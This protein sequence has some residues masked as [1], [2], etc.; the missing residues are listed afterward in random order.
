MMFKISERFILVSVVCKIYVVSNHIH[1]LV[2]VL[3]SGTCSHGFEN[4]IHGLETG[5]HGFENS[6]ETGT[7]GFENSL[8]SGIVSYFCLDS[9]F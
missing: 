9:F 5:T 2:G 7:H 1:G 3:E 6:N 4:S 8:E